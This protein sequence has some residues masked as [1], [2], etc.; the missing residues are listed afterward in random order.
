MLDKAGP[1][2]T[3]EELEEMKLL[4]FLSRSNYKLQRDLGLILELVILSQEDAKPI[5]L[6]DSRPKINGLWHSAILGLP[7][8]GK[9]VLS[10]LEVVRLAKE[11]DNFMAIIPDGE[12]DRTPRIITWMEQAGMHDKWLYFDK[13][14]ICENMFEL[15]EL[16]PKWFTDLSRVFVGRGFYGDT[17]TSHLRKYFTNANGPSLCK[18]RGGW[19]TFEEM[20]NY[21]NQDK[22]AKGSKRERY[23]DTIL[24]RMQGWLQVIGGIFNYRKGYPWDQLKGKVVIYDLTGLDFDAQVIFTDYLIAKAIFVRS[25]GL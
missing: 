20:V 2:L 15:A 9:S 21:I 11:T 19:A 18:A 7:G 13:S 17:G 10:D 24:E 3:G 14:T 1:L 4:L 5:K 8:T 6:L 12:G 25:M 16:D 22:P 23:K